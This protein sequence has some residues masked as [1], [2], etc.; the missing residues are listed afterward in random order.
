[1]EEATEEARSLLL[2]LL[3]LDEEAWV[4]M[5]V[6]D[7]VEVVMAVEA[8]SLESMAD[9][10]VVESTG[11]VVEAVVAAVVVETAERSKS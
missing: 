4:V 5:V 2:P 11:T 9:V 6:V 1:L 3:E 7:R 8:A 10:V